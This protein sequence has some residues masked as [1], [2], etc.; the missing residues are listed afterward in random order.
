M[1]PQFIE[2]DMPRYTKRALPGYRHLP[3]HNAHPFLDK[4]GHSFGEKLLPPDSFTT[5]DWQRCE[6]YLYSI[7]LFNHGFWW[8]AHERLKLVS[9]GAGRESK[10]GQ[11]VQ[12]LVQIAAALLKH[13]MGEQE[14]AAILAESGAGNLQRVQGTFLGIDVA[15]LVV[16]VQDCLQAEEAKY[17]R[18]RLKK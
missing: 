3:F 14:G 2:T 8:E 15:T 6:A 13:F 18:I 5:D 7:D 10:T 1:E 9:I 12:G 17:P 11:F 4:E 16:Q